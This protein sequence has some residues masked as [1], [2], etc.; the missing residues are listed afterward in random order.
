MV[1]MSELDERY[2]DAPEVVRLM[3]KAPTG[4]YVRCR[5]NSQG[6]LRYKFTKREPNKIGESSIGRLND[7]QNYSMETFTRMMMRE[8]SLWASAVFFMPGERD[9]NA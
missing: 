2:P 7:Y 5:V 9:D 4:A 3:W 6:R 8:R 1:C